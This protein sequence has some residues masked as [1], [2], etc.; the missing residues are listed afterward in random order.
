MS[1]TGMSYAVSGDQ[2][3][4]A[5]NHKRLT[6]CLATWLAYRSGFL[7]V[8]ETGYLGVKWAQLRLCPQGKCR[9][10]TPSL[11]ARRNAEY[12]TNTGSILAQRLR[13]CA[14]IEPAFGTRSQL[15]ATASF[16]YWVDLSRYC[17]HPDSYGLCCGA[18][19]AA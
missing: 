12:R 19:K 16:N 6:G 14:S 15:A 13:R 8:I 11:A 18:Y 10:Q 5:L 17:P 9:G 4:T 3:R 7:P 2:L 1:L